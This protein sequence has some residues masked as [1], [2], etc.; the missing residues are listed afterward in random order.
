MNLKWIKNI[1]FATCHRQLFITH[2][3]LK[4]ATWK[5]PLTC[6]SNLEWKF[7]IFGRVFWYSCWPEFFH[8]LSYSFWQ[9][10]R[11]IQ[12][13]SKFNWKSTDLPSEWSPEKASGAKKK[14]KFSMYPPFKS[15]QNTQICKS[16]TVIGGTWQRCVRCPARPRKWQ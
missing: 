16:K 7:E 1:F 2:L 10:L 14:K 15:L 12:R 13:L 11:V 5:L 9:S 3:R 4:L 6:N 8:S